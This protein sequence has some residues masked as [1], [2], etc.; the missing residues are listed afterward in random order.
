MKGFR[1]KGLGFRVTQVKE[2]RSLSK[3]MGTLAITCDGKYKAYSNL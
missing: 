3:K 1:V 2:M